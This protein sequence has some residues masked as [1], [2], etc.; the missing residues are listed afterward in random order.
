MLDLFE[1][2]TDVDLAVMR[3]G[4]QLPD[5]TADLIRGLGGT[6]AALE[7][8]WSIVQGDT[9]TAF[10][11]ALAELLRG[12][13]GCARRGRSPVRMRAHTIPRGGE[14]T[15]RRTPRNPSLLLRQ[16]EAR[17]TCW[18]R[19]SPATACWSP[20]TRSS[21]RSSGP[22][23]VPRRLPPSFRSNRRHRILLTVHRRENHGIGTPA[24]SATRFGSLAR[25]GDVEIVFP[26]HRSPSCD[27]S[28][29]RELSRVAGVP[30]ERPARLPRARQRPRRLRP[31]RSPTRAGCRRRVRRSGSRYSSF[32]MPRSD[33][34]RS[35]RVSHGSW[36]RIRSAIVKAVALLL[37]DPLAYAAMARIESPFGDGRASTRGSSTRSEESARPS[38]SSMSV[39]RLIPRR[40]R[41]RD[42]RRGPS[43][44]C[45]SSS[46]ASSTPDLPPLAA[47]AASS[48]AAD[49]ARRHPA[50]HLR[51][52]RFDARALRRTG[53]WSWLGEL[54]AT[55]T[56]ESR[57]TLRALCTSLR[58]PS[59]RRGEIERYT[60]CRL[61]RIDVQRDSF[62][63]RSSTT[64]SAPRGLFCGSTTTCSS[65]VRA[66][67]DSSAR[68]GWHPTSFDRSPRSPRC[69]QGLGAHTLGTSG[70]R[71]HGLRDR[72]LTRL[73]CLRA[74][75]VTTARASPGRCAPE[76]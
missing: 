2:R 12:R 21:T 47:R 28:S 65:S 19:A 56:V 25:R 62:R 35:R 73:M 61:C 60:R 71:N 14:S 49:L 54:Y 29:N 18:P 75:S 9:T 3:P 33:P 20:G 72:R 32:A 39:N 66:A 5:L 45:A 16:S 51:P 6:I 17:R 27:P 8:D 10:C 37:D 53:R 48:A 76:I 1:L 34:R 36:A 24:A 55:M 30:S 52:R 4:Q 23:D 50:G 31:R 15:T 13:P 64:S 43:S 44:R 69:L 70:E 26:V 57:R 7:P 68:Y 22:S 11:G 58:S 67:P 74:R 40:R 42:R 41:R 46:A 59:Y 38:G 63:T